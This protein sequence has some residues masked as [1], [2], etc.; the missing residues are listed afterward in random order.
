VPLLPAAGTAFTPLAL[1][2]E[3]FDSYSQTWS[4]LGDEE[5]LPTQRARLAVRLL[6]SAA[7]C[8]LTALPTSSENDATAA[9]LV[10]DAKAAVEILLAQELPED[11][12]TNKASAAEVRRRLLHVAWLYDIAILFWLM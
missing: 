10:H 1:A 4:V 8:A 7:R 5:A 2:Q 12:F 6:G 3:P 9:Q 11:E